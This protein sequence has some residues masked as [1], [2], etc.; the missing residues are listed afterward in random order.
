MDTLELY[1][2]AEAADVPVLSLNI[3]ENQSMSLQTNCR[4]YI[5]MDFG[6]LEEDAA[7]KVH[8]AHELGHCMTGAFY[9]RWAS[10]DVRQKHENR[11]NRWAIEHVI[12]SDELE[13]AVTGGHTDLWDL[14]EVFG[15]T[16]EFMKKAILYYRKRK[17]TYIADHEV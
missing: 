10:M 2:Q 8:L 14:A 5:G 1:Q 12:P 4:Y 11:A 16:E 7:I 17:N 3:P 9:N 15:V 13:A 6:I